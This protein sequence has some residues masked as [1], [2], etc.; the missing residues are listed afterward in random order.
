MNSTTKLITL[1]VAIALCLTGVGALVWYLS[2]S[3]QQSPP[4]TAAIEG[5][6]FNT[7]ITWGQEGDISIKARDFTDAAASLGYAHGW[8]HAWSIAL[9]RQAALG[10][11]GEWFGADALPADALARHLGFAV[12]AK[13]S[14]GALAPEDQRLLSAYAS[15]LNAALQHP[16]VGL[17]QE[18]LILETIP[19]PWLEWHT[20]ALERLFAWLASTPPPRDAFTDS[21]VA[22]FY[23]ADASLRRRINIHGFENS[24]AWVASDESGS[25]LF[26]RH[27]Y[28]DTALPALQETALQLER[29]GYIH[30][31]TLPGTPFFPAGQSANGVWAVLL[32]S[33][34]RL[35]Q[36]ARPATEAFHERLR[37]RD[38]AERLIAF[39]R[40]ENALPLVT[41]QGAE[42][43]WILEW[44]GLTPG[45]DIAAWKDLP[46][47]AGSSFGLLDG[48]GLWMN[49]LGQWRVLGA[50]PVRTTLPS[51][52]LVGIAPWSRHVGD[53]LAE[54]DGEP[55]AIEQ[56][57]EDSFSAW[58]AA[59]APL[60][61]QA[62][63]NSPNP[64]ASALT[65]LRNWDFAFDQASIGA[66]IF[67]Q[68]METYQHIYGAE[69]GPASD[70]AQLAAALEK[71]L[72]ALNV[73]FG[74]HQ[75]QWR[76]ERMHPERRYFS[77]TAHEETGGSSRFAPLEWPGH[78][79]PTSMAWG[80]APSLGELEAS[81]AW[82]AWFQTDAWETMSVRRRRV[83]PYAPLG[84]YVAADSNP[85]TVTLPSLAQSTTILH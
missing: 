54:Q 39:E 49:Q 37:T 20:L 30:G 24:I 58:A 60:L 27:V 64:P 16:A 53:F 48:H 66:S 7:R 9:W 12:L 43:V 63:S 5:L 85:V 65:Y 57:I 82:E 50:P 76:W 47:G 8:E 31:A 10:R 46:L 2:Y 28:G 13:A 55:I 25:T 80:D 81:A 21:D 41:S 22:A 14:M 15:G 69:A 32:S 26:Q 61:V 34:A 75:S 40:S 38:G 33:S 62:V 52:M 6:S 19:K 17:G 73:R 3:V 11:L 71:A 45:S 23:E 35:T 74:A 1:L 56:W 79:H 83:N 70:E 84:R 42:S 67:A 29:G 18:F 78:G 72:E 77:I 36:A 68:W 44:A 4:A 59:T 51:G